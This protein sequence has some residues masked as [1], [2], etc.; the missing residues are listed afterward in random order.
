[1]RDR[2]EVVIIGAGIMGLAIAYNL[3]RHHGITDVVVLDE[4]YLCGGASGRNGGGVRA[5]FSSADNIQLMQESIRLCRDFAQEMKIN[6]WF[7]QGGYLF[8]A[9]SEA[10]ERRLQRNVELHAEVGAPTRLLTPAEAQAIVPQLDV[11]EVRLAT[12]NPEDGVVFP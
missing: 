5:Q 1:M 11:S 4:S 8:L 10:G 9:R 12:F 2:A 7:R 3:A 6:I